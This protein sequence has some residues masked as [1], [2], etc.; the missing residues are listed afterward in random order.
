MRGIRTGII[1]LE[2]KPPGADAIIARRVVVALTS[3]RYIWLQERL[4]ELLVQLLALSNSDE[5][6][7]RDYAVTMVAYPSDYMQGEYDETAAAL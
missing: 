2:Q 1:D 7:R 6:I 5:G 4:Q 3:A